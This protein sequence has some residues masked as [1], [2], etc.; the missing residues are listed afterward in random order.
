LALSCLSFASMSSMSRFISS[1]RRSFSRRF[2]AASASASCSR[3]H[4]SAYVSI[5][6]QC[7]RLLLASAYVSICQHT[8]PV[9]PP[10]ARVSIRQNM[11]AYAASASASCSRQHTSAFL[12]AD[13]RFP[14]ASALLIRRQS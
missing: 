13:A 12:R 3:Q 10:P 7:V 9:R 5:R 4:T 2:C 11:S 6:C 1:R 14:S 8:L